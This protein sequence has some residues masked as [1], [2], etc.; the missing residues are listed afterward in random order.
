VTSAGGQ[1]IVISQPDVRMLQQSRAAIRGVTELLLHEAGLDAEQVEA[2]YVTGV[3][4]SGLRM[5][6]AYRIGMLPRFP[7]AAITQHNRGTIEGADLLMISENRRV[8]EDAVNRLR[9]IEMA[10]NP[11]FESR[12]LASL[13]FP[14]Q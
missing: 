5:D 2:L 11:A 14:V 1:Q 3:F 10:G 7:K 8:I 6:D 12:Y 9:Y 4:G 13:P